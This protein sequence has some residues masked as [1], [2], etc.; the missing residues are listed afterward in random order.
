MKQLAALVAFSMMSVCVIAQTD[1]ITGRVHQ[2]EGVTITETQRQHEMTST[3]PFHVIDKS[4]M[5]TM[6]VVDIADALHRMPGITLRDYDTG[7]LRTTLS[8]H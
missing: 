5:L 3:V 2:L 6:G 1:T 8:N 7:G 4:D